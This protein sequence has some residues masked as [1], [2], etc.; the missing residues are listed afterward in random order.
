MKLKVQASSIP[1]QRRLGPRVGQE[2]TFPRGIPSS[3]DSRDPPSQQV[4]SSSFP[5]LANERSPLLPS[6]PWGEGLGGAVTAERVRTDEGETPPSARLLWGD[7]REL[8][9]RVHPSLWLGL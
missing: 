1:Y 8:C 2:L 9:G 4:F 7:G 3:Q 6:P 5:F